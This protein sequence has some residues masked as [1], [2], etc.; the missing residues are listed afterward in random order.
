MN[1]QGQLTIDL[2]D[3]P[4]QVETSRCAADWA[5]VLGGLLAGDLDFANDDVNTGLHNLHAFPAKYPP[6]LPRMFIEHLTKL[7]EVVL[8]PMV[9]S[10]TTIVEAASCGRHGV[11]IDIDPLALLL[12]H[13]KCDLPEPSRAYQTGLSICNRAQAQVE[14][15]KD[16]LFSCIQQRYDTRTRQFQDYWFL[17]ETQLELMALLKQIEAEPQGN[18]RQ[19]LQMCFSSIIITKSGGVSLAMDLAHTRPHRVTDKK[20][21]S[22]IE[23]FARKV[24]RNV[25]AIEQAGVLRGRADVLC[26]DARRLP[27]KDESVHLIVTSPPYAGS[28]IDYMRAHKFSLVWLGYSIDTLSRWRREYVGSDAYGEVSSHKLPNSVEQVLRQVR[29]RAPNRAKALQAYYTQMASVMRE[30]YR[31]LYPGRCAV[32]VVASSQMCGVDT[33]ADVCLTE[34]AENVGFRVVGVGRRRIHR[35]RRM[36]PASLHKHQL[37]GIERRMHEEYVIGLVK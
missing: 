4:G 17:P 6:A 2:H 3:K 18:L 25:S 23:E 26:A 27:L 14:R 16:A 37:N 31:V 33:Q 19:F 32:L 36:M 7:G 21:R 29:E 34:I 30:C 35:D 5:D 20:P 28:A 12:C 15:D 11:G 8:D 22:A 13:V 9:G 1:V 24:R 10:G